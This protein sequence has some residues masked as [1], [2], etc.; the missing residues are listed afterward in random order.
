MKKA[1][2]LALLMFTSV[3]SG[4]LNQGGDEE[5]DS[6][7]EEQREELG[8]WDV[9]LV[10]ETVDLPTCDQ[11]THGRLY[12]VEMISEFR[13][14]KST[15]WVAIE[16]G[17]SNNMTNLMLT[18]LEPAPSHCEAGGFIENFGRDDGANQGIPNNG[19]LEEGEIEQSVLYC[20]N[21]IQEVFY[22]VG[23]DSALRHEFS[24]ETHMFYSE[25][26]TS[27]NTWKLFSLHFETQTSEF[28]LFHTDVDFGTETE[29]GSVISA[30]YNGQV[31]L[32]ITD[33][34]QNGTEI[35]TEIPGVLVFAEELNGDILYV[36]SADLG[37]LYA[38]I[39]GTGEIETI[40]HEE[41]QIRIQKEGD[42]L[43]YWGLGYISK[44][45][46]IVSDPQYWS[47]LASFDTEAGQPEIYGYR[48]SV[49]YECV[50][51]DIPSL[52]YE[53]SPIA[54]MNSS[55]ELIPDE[56]ITT[57][58]NYILYR[59]TMDELILT[60]FS[61]NGIINLG[62]TNNYVSAVVIGDKLIINN[63]YVIYEFNM[64]SKTF[65]KIGDSP[66]LWYEVT[67]VYGNK[68]FFFESDTGTH[69]LLSFDVRTQIMNSYQ[70]T[71]AL[72]YSNPFDESLTATEDG[73]FWV[74]RDSIFP[75][76]EAIFWNRG[77]E[78]TVHIL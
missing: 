1:L 40:S 64:T 68:I 54:G 39:E 2:L 49:V 13:V 70:N 36:T 59:T 28:L 32:L 7:E 62:E 33:G 48:D 76:S 29:N 75:Y 9:Y 31:N 45:T 20:S 37:R 23:H 53:N 63:N 12:Y 26:E 35:V 44:T 10:S 5:E 14:C 4:C 56:I 52:C 6:D 38:Y 22:G 47:S 15:G 30:R 3:L 73:V 66:N 58:G 46:E 42:T 19:I 67:A 61:Y 69:Q 21:Y 50:Y 57:A 65:Q 24:T 17:S 71:S 74:D 77:V 11:Q 51:F 34:T 8:D 27:N 18:E 60:N 41:Y 72:L 43:Y 16:L 55:A 25:Y 78:T